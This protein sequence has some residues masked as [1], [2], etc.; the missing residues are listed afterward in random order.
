MLALMRFVFSLLAVFLLT[1]TPALAQPVDITPK[2]HMRAS[3]YYGAGSIGTMSANSYDNDYSDAS[4]L[5]TRTGSGEGGHGAGG[6][7][8]GYAAANMIAPGGHTQA[9]GG[10]YRDQNFTFIPPGGGA[11][12]FQPSYYSGQTQLQSMQQWND[13][14]KV[15][16]MPAL[17]DGAYFQGNDATPLQN[18]PYHIVVSNN[19]EWMQ[20]WQQHTGR[21]PPGRL[22]PGQVGVAYV[23]GNRSF[24][25]YQARVSIIGERGNN[26]QVAV[27]EASP[28]AQ[29]AQARGD[30]S[31]YA[32]LVVGAG[33]KG[34]E[35]VRNRSLMLPDYNYAADAKAQNIRWDPAVFYSGIYN[36]PGSAKDQ[37]GN[38]KNA[39]QTTRRQCSFNQQCK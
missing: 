25:G 20:M 14:T 36:V 28:G 29:V 1:P 37:A 19:A 8:S 9:I 5:L 33:S 38:Q 30:N 32:V 3:P 15:S 12:A 39:G 4:D 10:G 31:P 7:G 23:L 18:Q 16:S 13:Q 35:V 27:T 21:N 24:T 22:A 11:D 6:F 2:N 34:V 26:I 17:Q